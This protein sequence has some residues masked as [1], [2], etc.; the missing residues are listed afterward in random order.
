MIDSR[1]IEAKKPRRPPSVPGIVK[2]LLRVKSNLVRSLHHTYRTGRRDCPVF[3][4]DVAQQKSDIDLLSAE[5]KREWNEV[6]WERDMRKLDRV[7]TCA[8]SEFFREIKRVYQYRDTRGNDDEAFIFDDTPANRDTLRSTTPIALSNGRL[9]VSGADVDQVLGN[10]LESTFN[11][12]DGGVLEEDSVSDAPKL[13][14]SHAVRSDACPD[15]RFIA[16]ARL[17]ELIKGINRKHS[18]GPDGIPN[19]VIRLLPASIRKILLVILNNCINLNRIPRIWKVSTVV[20]IKKDAGK[21]GDVGNYR[22]ISLLCNMSKILERFYVDQLEEEIVARHLISANQFGFRPRVGT[23]HAIGKLVGLINEQRALG[24][25][26]AVIFVDLQ[27]A[28]DSVDHKLLIERLRALGING[29]VIDYFENFLSGRR[30]ILSRTMGKLSGVGDLHQVDSHSVNC[31]VLQ[32]SISGPLLFILFMNELVTHRN[33]VGFADDLAMVISNEFALPLQEETQREF[34]ALHGKCR[35]L[36]LTINMGKTKIVLFRDTTDKQNS[37]CKEAVQTFCVKLRDTFGRGCVIPGPQLEVVDQFNYLGVTLD[38]LLKFDKHVT[39]IVSSAGRIYR[40]VEQIMQLQGLEESRRV[41]VYK[42]M[43]R[44]FLTYA[45]PVWALL[46]PTLMAQITK[47]EYHIL[48]A[49]FGK[50]RRRN[51]RFVSYRS[52]LLKANLPGVDYQIIKLARR[53]LVKLDG[54]SCARV[55]QENPDWLSEMRLIERRRFVPESTMFIDALGLLQDTQGRNEFYAL[56]RPANDKGFD[57]A[58]ALDRRIP[59]R[60]MRLPNKWEREANSQLEPPWREWVVP[61][62]WRSMIH[63]AE[64]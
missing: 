40:G 60:K 12:A 8:P 46:T 48:R 11:P 34:L 31:G 20:F 22:P 2:E 10:V 15:P 4:M 64:G 44:P 38:Y 63:A 27:K 21:Q 26:V 55:D 23:T 53:H 52:R 29:D 58:S 43:I 54:T 13:M 18:S 25:Y 5:I 45:C 39:R 36:K 61:E 9:L 42:V 57:L 30:F 35:N 37:T 17:S 41:W 56:R 1:D 7:R 3:Q 33:A 16:P 32:G 28:F 62:R 19:S 51:G 50:Y 24:R 59:R 6:Q 14:F 47:V 49:L